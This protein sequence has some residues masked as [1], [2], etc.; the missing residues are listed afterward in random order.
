MN[1]LSLVEQHGLQPRKVSTAKGGEYACACPF[2]DCG[3][4]HNSD[5]FHIWP[6]QG[7]AGTWWCRRCDR[8]GDAIKLLM[9]LDGKTFRE[10]A[11]IVGKRVDPRPAVRTPRMPAPVQTTASV[12]RPVRLPSQAWMD[13][14][15]AVAT[16]AAAHLLGS[17]ER[18][19]WLAARGITAKTAARF[20]LGWND[21]PIIRPYPAWG[22]PA[23]V[24]PES[25]KPKF[26]RVPAGLVIPWRDGGRVLRLRVRQL[27]AEPKYYVIPGGAKDP[28]PMTVIDG[29]WSG[30]H[31][32][33][34]LCEAELDAMLLAQ[35]AGDLVTVV[36]LGSA[37]TRPED[38]RAVAAVTGAAW[39]GLWLDRD[40]A[41]DD[42]TAKWISAHADTAEDIRPHGTG[43]MDPG[44]AHA[45]GMDIRAHLL[46][47]LPPVWRSG[48]SALD[49]ADEGGG[50]SQEKR[51]R[52]E[53]GGGGQRARV[54]AAAQA[55]A[56]RLPGVRRGHGHHGCQATAGWAAC[57]GLAVGDGALG[58]DARGVQAVLV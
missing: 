34:V 4:E 46:R 53:P 26:V 9:D 21:G 55:R 45:S 2:A 13:R 25:G 18:L 51:V 11:A 7:E 8:G 54:R 31:R 36:A 42:Y 37:Q 41:G 49:Q 48:R 50:A 28:Q 22:L 12:A 16:A 30:P 5:R 10:A 35:E 39:L 27:D 38:P 14:A 47:H 44:D 6:D 33:V 19:E 56:N 52:G 20:G 1:V 43:K 15:D 57:A 3:G 29:T 58:A 23:E 24:W 32:A 17:P 40:Q